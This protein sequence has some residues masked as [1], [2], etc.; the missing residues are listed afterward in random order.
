MK[1]DLLQ[2]QKWQKKR[3]EKKFYCCWNP[4]GGVCKQRIYSNE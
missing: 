1:D 3:K 4:S 2:T